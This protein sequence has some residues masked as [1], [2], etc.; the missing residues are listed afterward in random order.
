MRVNRSRVG[1]SHQSL[2]ANVICLP[3][4]TG[5]C[6]QPHSLDHSQQPYCHLHFCCHPSPSCLSLWKVTRCRQ[7]P[8]LYAQISPKVSNLSLLSF[9][10]VPLCLD[11]LCYSLDLPVSLGFMCSK[12]GFPGWYHWKAAEALKDEASEIFRSVVVLALKSKGK[13]LYAEAAKIYSKNKPFVPP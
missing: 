8:E 1:C 6:S 9:K 7:P 10:I 5:G 12:A 3:P 13:N 2:V 4:G 11:G